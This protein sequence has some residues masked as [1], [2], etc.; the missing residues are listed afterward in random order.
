MVAMADW[1]PGRA[2]RCLEPKENRAMTVRWKPLVILSGLFLVVALIGVVA[3]TLTLV[4]RSTQSFLRRARVAHNAGRFEEA[5]I[6]FKQALQIDAKDATVHDEFASFYRDWAKHAPAE[7]RAVLVN[8]RH[9]HLESAVKFDKAIKGPRLELLK[10]ALRDDLVAESNYWAKEVLK[11]ESENLDAHFVLAL[12][13]LENRTPNVPDVRRHLEVLEKKKAPAIRRLLVRAK[14][15]EST[16]EKGA[17]DEAFEQARAIK[18]GPESD[19]VDRMAGLRIISLAIRVEADLARLDREVSSM[20][21]QVNDLAQADEVAPARVA[22]VRMLLEQTQRALILR[23]GRV[24]AAARK[25][26]DRQ[27]D[28]IEVQLESMFQLAL[29]GDHDPDLQTYLAYADHLRGQGQPNR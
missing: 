22:R 10:D 8:E 3:I 28:A 6:D 20:L 18:L 17:R 11:V 27:V 19:P 14:L 23:S 5:E 16:G 4:P 25:G 26:I 12:E 21:R 13:A 1:L 24:T 7:K 15:A 2:V 9:N 29:G